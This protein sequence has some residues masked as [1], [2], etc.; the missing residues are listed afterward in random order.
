[1]RFDE[2]LAGI[3]RFTAL[4]SLWSVALAGFGYVIALRTGK[5]GAVNSSFSLF[6]PSLLPT[7]SWCPRDQVSGWP[8][9][10][11]GFNPVTDLPQG[12]RSVVLVDGW[13]RGELAQALAAIGVVGAVSMS[14]CFAALRG[15]LQRG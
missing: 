12:M 14:L 1:M 7:P 11:A 4:A 6:F 2:G 8:D 10:I 5:P 13:Q 9:A 3:A 15:R